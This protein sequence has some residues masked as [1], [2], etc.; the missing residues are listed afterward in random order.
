M[1]RE[2]KCVGSHFLI[3]EKRHWKS[4]APW[5]DD[6]RGLVRVSCHESHFLYS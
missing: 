5:R 2:E 4:C 3:A 1:R 6:E